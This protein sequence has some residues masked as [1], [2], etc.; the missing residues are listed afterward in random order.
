MKPYR[1]RTRPPARPDLTR[2][3]SLLGP[4]NDE[5]LTGFIGDM[6]ASDLEERY[7]RALAKY[8]IPSQFRVRITP[9]LNG[10]KRL[11][12]NFANVRGE[13][14]IDHIAVAVSSMDEALK[15]FRELYGLEPEHTETVA[16]DR[17]TEAMLPVGGTY[18][19]LLEATDSES[20]VAKF[21]ER[22]GE[23]L[24]HIAIRVNDLE[25]TLTRLKERGAQ[26][27]DE[28]P[29]RGGG[30]HRVA[31]VHPK[32]THGILI[33]LVEL[34]PHG[35]EAGDNGLVVDEVTGEEADRRLVLYPR[36]GG[37]ACQP[38]LERA[39]ALVG[40]AIV[41]SFRR[42]AGQTFPA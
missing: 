18:L 30:G 39:S 19:Q 14:E 32:T 33:E 31:F 12:T 17:I 10:R 35:R 38:S 16:S 26:L 41:R 23:G 15:T 22:R 13:V 34:G 42:L 6:Q 2:P 24:H 3:P 9:L 20:T 21:I 37:R 5:H 4:D 29:R 25:A 8:E 28:V 7:F 36:E 11:T 27:L 1:Y 40:E